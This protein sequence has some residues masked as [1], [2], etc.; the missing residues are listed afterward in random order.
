MI[1]PSPKASRADSVADGRG[2]EG[3]DA[4][5]AGL[6][7]LAAARLIL[8]HAIAGHQFGVEVVEN[9]PVGDPSL[10]E[11]MEEQ[12]AR[13]DER[14]DVAAEPGRQQR[15]DLAQELPLASRPFQK[16]RGGGVPQRWLCPVPIHPLIQSSAS[17]PVK[18]HTG[19]AYGPQLWRW[20]GLVFIVLV[21][22]IVL[23]LVPTIRPSGRIVASPGGE[24]KRKTRRGEV[25]AGA[26]DGA[27]PRGA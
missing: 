8:E 6:G 23:R 7:Q 13:A 21:L 16:R 26:A 22:A 25:A 10:A 14:L 11:E 1:R 27:A 4:V 20:P 9:R 18:S 5:E 3:V 24:Y 19:Q 2:R 12:R 17:P 15:L